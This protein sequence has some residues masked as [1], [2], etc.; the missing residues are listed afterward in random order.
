MVELVTS[1]QAGRMFRPG[2]GAGW[3]H[4]RT[5]SLH[6]QTGKRPSAAGGR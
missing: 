3:Q 1:A 2:P 4:S 6:V 5:T